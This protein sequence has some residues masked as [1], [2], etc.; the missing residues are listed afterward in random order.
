MGL[1]VSVESGLVSMKSSANSASEIVGGAVAA[2]AAAS[3]VGVGLLPG[4]LW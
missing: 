1:D 4:C 3:T 2:T